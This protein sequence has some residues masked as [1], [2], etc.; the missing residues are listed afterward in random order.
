MK[1]ETSKNK[2]TKSKIKIE[3]Q[4]TFFIVS[5]G[6]IE[7]CGIFKKRTIYSY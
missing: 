2:I 5:Q 1:I 6:G 7:Q 4:K 3:N